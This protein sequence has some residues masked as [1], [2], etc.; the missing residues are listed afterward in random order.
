MSPEHLGDVRKNEC[1]AECQEAL[2]QVAPVDER[3]NRGEQGDP[4]QAADDDGEGSRGED[5]IAPQAHRQGYRDVST[6]E[7]QRPVGEV[8]DVHQAEE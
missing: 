5:T 4:E 1:E 3:A 8:Q 7:Q 2:V 6:H